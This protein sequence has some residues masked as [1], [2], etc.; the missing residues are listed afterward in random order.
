MS[1]NQLLVVGKSIAGARPDKSPYEMRRENLLPTF[2][3]SPRF[4][5]KRKEEN[6]AVQGD[7]LA[8]MEKKTIE[9]ADPSATAASPFR[10]M[11][12]KNPESLF[13]SAPAIPALPK[14][15]R[16]WLSWLLAKMFGR[17]G[18]RN[19]FV[20]SELTLENVRVLRNDLENSDLELVMKKKR[21]RKEN[22]KPGRPGPS[23][24][25]PRSSAWNELTARLFE[26][27]QQ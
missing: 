12:T 3:G 8:A 20:Q 13:Q 1:L 5:G 25:R 22:A 10:P 17:P 26:I 4:T 18:L 15:R 23:G 24:A 16:R 14:R 2:E 19:D 6:C 27:G 9:P 21:A 11:P 7:L